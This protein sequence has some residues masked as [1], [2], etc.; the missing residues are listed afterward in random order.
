MSFDVTTFILEI[1]NFLV[2]LWLLRKLL[3]RPVMDVINKRR[4]TIEKK[5]FDAQQA[6]EEALAKE[7]QYKSRLIEWEK[8][9]QRLKVALEQ[10]LEL[11]RQRQLAKLREDLE[12]EQSKTRARAE[13]NRKEESLQCERQAIELAAKHAANVLRRFASSDLERQ[14]CEVFVEDL[15]RFDPE[16]FLRIMN[17]SESAVSMVQVTTAYP[18]TSELKESIAVALRQK[19]GPNCQLE[20]GQDASL[21]AGIRVVTVGGVL[22]ANLCDAVQFFR[23]V[24]GNGAG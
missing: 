22:E 15:V 3:Y 13:A 2:L 7:E 23:G 9:R 24:E 4:A 17:H 19:L 14:I 10:E 8:E 5:V 20:F 1:I 18:P 11:E 12:E 16:Q 21:I 6:L